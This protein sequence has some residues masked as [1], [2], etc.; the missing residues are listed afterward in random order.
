MGAAEGVIMP[1]II[2]VHMRRTKTNSAVPHA[3]DT[4]ANIEPMW[5]MWDIVPAVAPMGVA[6][7]SLGMVMP[8]A[9]QST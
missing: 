6:L 4:G 2:T 5:P 1:I 9:S 7:P 3:V 8:N